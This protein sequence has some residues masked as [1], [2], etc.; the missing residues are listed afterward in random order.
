VWLRKC[1]LATG[2]GA[3]VM[4]MVHSLGKRKTALAVPERFL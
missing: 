4:G 1:F 3:G 2:S